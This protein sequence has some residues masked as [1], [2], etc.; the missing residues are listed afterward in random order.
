MVIEDGLMGIYKGLIPT[1][2]RQGGTQATRYS[3]YNWAKVF[4]GDYFGYIPC[5]FFP[6][7]LNPKFRSN[8][9]GWDA[10]RRVR[11]LRHKPN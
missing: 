3:V 11:D 9:N 2:L 6:K 10:R 4:L 7:T 8:N 1:M 5:K